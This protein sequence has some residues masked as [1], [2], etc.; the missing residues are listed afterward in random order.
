MR[1]L[2]SLDW[3]PHG[4]VPGLLRAGGARRKSGTLLL[5]AEECRQI[6]WSAKALVQLV[7]YLHSPQLT[8]RLK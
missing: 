1:V 2:P 5:T 7:V 4:Q 3:K 8:E 6:M